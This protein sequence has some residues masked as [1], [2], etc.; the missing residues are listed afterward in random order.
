M[1]S[2]QGV[3]G[4]RE[5]RSR[6]GLGSGFYFEEVGRAKNVG[7]SGG[8]YLTVVE[9]AGVRVEVHDLKVIGQVQAEV[10]TPIREILVLVVNPLMKS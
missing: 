3:D 4:H 6:R 2:F 7:R 1:H 9:S 10:P 8:E 5:A